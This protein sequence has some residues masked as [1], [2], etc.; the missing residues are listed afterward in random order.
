MKKKIIIFVSI[1]LFVGIISALA[2]FLLIKP[3][4]NNNTNKEEEI[5]NLAGQEVYKGVYLY[6]I[7]K[8]GDESRH[9]TIIEDDGIYTLVYHDKNDEIYKTNIYTNKNEKIKDISLEDDKYCYVENNYIVCDTKENKTILNTNLEEVYNGKPEK[10]IPYKNSIIKIDG[11]KIYYNDSEYGKVNRDFKDYNVYRYSLFNNN[12]FIYYG[13]FDEENCLYNF[14][15]NKCEE[16]DFYSVKE[17]KDGLFYLEKNKIKTINTE[18]NERKEYDNPIENLVTDYAQLYDNQLIYFKDDYIRFYN[19][20]TKKI[21]FLD[22][23]MNISLLDIKTYNNYLYL[24]SEDKA[25]IIDL[26]NIETKELSEEE[27]NTHLENLLQEKIKDIKDNY[28][29]DIH[30]REEADLKF[31]MWDQKIKGE[32]AYDSINDSLDYIKE[33]LELLGKDLFKEFIHG[34][35]TGFAVYLASEINSPN[36]IGGEQ[37][38]YYDKYSIISLSSGVKSTFCH[39][40][41]HAM[42]DAIE[43]KNKTIFKEWNKYNPKGF[44]YGS[45]NYYTTFSAQKYSIDFGGNDIYF[46]DNYAETSALEDRARIF[47]NLCIG[48]TEVITKYPNI[49]KKAQYQMSEVIKNYPM[50]KESPIWDPIKETN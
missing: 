35:Y 9:Q 39:E 49:L 31:D 4:K 34:T 23:R 11:A 46:I 32:R 2:V 25:Y 33:D 10:V 19:L 6:N 14:N 20:D 42:E 40:L 1:I 38:R 3:E 22:F 48:N 28:G 16:F 13:N 45:F 27:I 50:L 43:T 12:A 5:K 7:E 41:M 21:N 15:D 29:I 44:E 26:K 8:D 24:L 36:S 47:E 30:I 18:L 17:Y 37:L